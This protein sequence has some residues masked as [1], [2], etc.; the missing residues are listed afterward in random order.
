MYIKWHI[1]KWNVKHNFS[2][3]VFIRSRFQKET[4]REGKK[5]ADGTGAMICWLEMV[6]SM[7][8]EKLWMVFWICACP[9]KQWPPVSN[10]AGEQT[11]GERWE[12]QMDIFVG[13]TYIRTR[14]KRGA[15]K[16][17][18]WSTTKDAGPCHRKVCSWSVFSYYHRYNFTVWLLG[19]K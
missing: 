15:E 13:K 18:I 9:H 14:R 5:K 7:A 17:F 10:D 2:I 16:N 4:K 1:Q 6:I 8:T 12:K 3:P 11:W 19:A